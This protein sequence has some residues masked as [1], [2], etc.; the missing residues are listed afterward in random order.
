MLFKIVLNIKITIYTTNIYFFDKKSS[1]LFIN[2]LLKTMSIILNVVYKNIEIKSGIDKTLYSIAFL[3]SSSNMHIKP[4][5]S[6]Q[7]KQ[8]I[9]KENGL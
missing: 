7:P 1:V 3:K 9:P 6:P 2:S 4:L 5:V 8:E